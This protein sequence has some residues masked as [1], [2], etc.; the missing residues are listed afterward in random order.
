MAIQD[1]PLDKVSLIALFSG[2]SA[3]LLKASILNNPWLVLILK[4]A[5]RINK[6][7]VVKRVFLGTS[8]LLLRKSL[9]ISV[10]PSL[11]MSMYKSLV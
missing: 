10:I 3:C 7:I 8:S 9:S 6:D 1:I 5:T 2:R 11:E 4:V